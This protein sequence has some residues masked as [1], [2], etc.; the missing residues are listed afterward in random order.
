MSSAFRNTWALFLGVALI[1]LGGGLQNSLIG[2]RAELEAFA[3]TVIGMIMS[4]FY[5]G[6]LAGSIIVPRIVQTVGHI[7]AFAALASLASTSVLIHVLIV[8]PTV[9][10][11]MRLV[12]GFSYAGLYIVAESWLND[13]ATNENRGRLLSAYMVVSLGAMGLGQLLLNVESPADFHLFVLVSVLISLALIPMLL[14]AAPAPSFE[15]PENVGVRQ[16]YRTSPLGVVGCFGVGAAHGA[17]L[18]MGAV[19]ARSAGLSVAEVSIFMGGV[20]LGGVVL[21]WPIGRLSDYYDRRKVLT[22]V[23]FLAA[24]VA[25]AA[26]GATAA[27]GRVGFARDALFVLMALFGGLAMP[28]YSLCVSHTNDYLSPRQMVAASASLYLVTGVGAVLGPLGVSAVMAQLGPFGFYAFLAAIH[29][30]IGGFAIWRMSRRAAR[31]LE[32]QGSYAVWTPGSTQVATVMAAEESGEELAER[33]SAADGEM[34]DAGPEDRRQVGET[35][36]ADEP[37]GADREPSGEDQLMR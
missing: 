33:E 12:T 15:A 36:T 8:D 34:A 14:T 7:R 26:L 35:S 18:A 30:A 31:P 23:T 21:Q 5:V 25:V 4:A 10:A 6:F 2:V 16:L 20:Y 17:L 28:M 27:L 9:W 1:M 32:E 3:T 19:F 13:R 11:V 29:A 24:A 22:V 37:A